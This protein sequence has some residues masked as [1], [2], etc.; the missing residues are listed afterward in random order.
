MGRLKNKAREMRTRKIYE[1]H[2][3]MVYVRSVQDNGSVR[4]LFRQ[5]VGG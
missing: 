3:E 4:L 5:V 2:I 1:K